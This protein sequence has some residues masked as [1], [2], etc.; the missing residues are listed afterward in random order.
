M[1]HGGMKRS[2]LLIEAVIAFSVALIILS[3]GGTLI[4]SFIHSQ[5]QSTL[6]FHEALYKRALIT[7]LRSFVGSLEATKG[8]KPLVLYKD[9]GSFG[10][11]LLFMGN[12][13]T[14]RNPQ[15]ANSVLYYL[16]VDKEGLKVAMR[17]D[18]ERK[19]M[20]QDKEAIYLVWPK[21]TKV[22]FCFFGAKNLSNQS[23]EWST[24]WNEKEAPLA[25]QTSIESKEFP[26]VVVTSLIEKS[27][28]AL[29]PLKIGL[30]SDQLGS[31]SS[32]KDEGQEE[33]E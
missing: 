19:K 4:Y 30:T 14:F 29:K 2:F 12:N 9:N 31:L 3:V 8:K 32:P 15:L 27:V 26:P 16:F 10:D 11:R 23:L 13:G 21:A 20:D 6:Q 33:A 18:P 24:E 5:K 17:A 25:I 1:C 22:T 28:T 7:R